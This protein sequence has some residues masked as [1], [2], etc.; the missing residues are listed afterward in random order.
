MLAYERDR[1]CQAKRDVA[2]KKTKVVTK[3]LIVSSSWI[4]SVKQRFKA[5]LIVNVVVRLNQRL[6]FVSE[7]E[8]FEAIFL[9]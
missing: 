8:R 4:L 1:I 5:I 3:A 9:M 2:A 7:A 6:N